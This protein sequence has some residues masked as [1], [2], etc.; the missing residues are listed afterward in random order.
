[1]ESFLKIYGYVERLWF[2]ELR[3]ADNKFLGYTVRIKNNPIIMSFLNQ[4]QEDT[5]KDSP[6]YCYFLMGVFKTLFEGLLGCTVYVT[7]VECQL[8]NEQYC[9]YRIMKG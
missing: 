1:M 3:D 7:K 2:I 5:D 9:E 4:A 6:S 8:R